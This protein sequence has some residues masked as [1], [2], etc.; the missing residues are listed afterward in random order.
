[1]HTLAANCLR[2]DSWTGRT[3]VVCLRDNRPHPFPS[4]PLKSFQQTPGQR[5]IEG[6]QAIPYTAR[7][8]SN[9]LSGWLLRFLLDLELELRLF[10][11]QISVAK[12]IAPRQ[13]TCPIHIDKPVF[14]KPG[15]TLIVVRMVV[16]DDLI[17]RPAAVTALLAV[18]RSDFLGQTLLCHFCDVMTRCFTV[19]QVQTMLTARPAIASRFNSISP[20]A[21]KENRLERLPGLLRARR[22]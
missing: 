2:W 13:R 8:H 10:D 6:N 7:N 17:N 15:V 3:G 18:A 22:Q 20:T 19:P 9:H 12:A 11:R 1:M 14:D 4:G 21:G 5:V 16:E